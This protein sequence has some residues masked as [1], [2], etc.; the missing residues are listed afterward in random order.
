MSC[1]LTGGKENGA[2]VGAVCSLNPGPRL[3]LESS[4]GVCNSGPFSIFTSTSAPL[5]A[6]AVVTNQGGSRCPVWCAVLQ[7]SKE[8]ACSSHCDMDSESYF[9][10]CKEKAD[11]LELLGHTL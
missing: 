7:R 6:D 11:M 4:G 2:G 3:Q 10:V 9:S 5:Q 1:L 8:G